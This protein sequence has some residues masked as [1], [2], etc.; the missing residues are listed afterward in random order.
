MKVQRVVK[1]V[2]SWDKEEARRYHQ[3]DAVLIAYW[4]DITPLFLHVV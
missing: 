3:A 1:G 2:A 4:K